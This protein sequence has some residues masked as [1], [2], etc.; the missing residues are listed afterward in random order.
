MKSYLSQ[1]AQV[2]SHGHINTTGWRAGISQKASIALHQT[3]RLR[4]ISIPSEFINAG[5]TP[6]H[7]LNSTAQNMRLFRL[8]L[9][10]SWCQSLV[11]SIYKFQGQ[12]PIPRPLINATCFSFDSGFVSPSTIIAFVPTCYT[13]K[14]PFFVRSIT[15]L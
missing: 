15:H 2:G 4:V 3:L 9:Y 11:F 6:K 8:Y 10:T 7:P 13:A 12:G 5:V 1:A 14:F